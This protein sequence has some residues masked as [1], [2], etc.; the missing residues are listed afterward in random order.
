LISP[1]QDLAAAAA[2]K[3]PSPLSSALQ[4]LGS[5]LGSYAGRGGNRQ[6]SG[7]AQPQYYPSASSGDNLDWG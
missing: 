7:G 1:E 2:Y 3:T 5:M 6:A 4:G